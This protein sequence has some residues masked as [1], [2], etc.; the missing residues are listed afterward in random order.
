MLEELLDDI[1]A[2]DISHQLKRVGLDFAEQLFLLITVCCFQLLLDEPR[3]MLI[4]AEL[5]HMIIYVLLEVK[6]CQRY[7]S[8]IQT[9]SS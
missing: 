1:V 3:S 4:A 9:F 6:L 5:Y 2:E 8:W 7:G